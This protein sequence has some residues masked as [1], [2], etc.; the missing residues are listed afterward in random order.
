MVFI[1]QTGA[2]KIAEEKA[3]KPKQEQVK[4]DSAFLP[5]MT[6]LSALV[7]IPKSQGINTSDKVSND[8]L[9]AMGKKNEARLNS[10]ANFI[11]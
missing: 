10:F 1:F 11:A 5:K 6:P 7:E 8:V 3:Q 4:R 9:L 2:Q